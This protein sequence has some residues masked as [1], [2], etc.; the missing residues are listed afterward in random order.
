[1]I[2]VGKD[3]T[4]RTFKFELKLNNEIVMEGDGFDSSSEIFIELH[5]IFKSMLEDYDH[6]FRV[7]TPSCTQGYMPA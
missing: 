2:K 7:N 6:F 1:M 4:G 5:K 3:E